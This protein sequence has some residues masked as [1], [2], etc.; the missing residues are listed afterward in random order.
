MAKVYKYKRGD[1]VKVVKKAYEQG[2]WTEEMNE[3]VGDGN[4]YPVTSVWDSN[5][6]VVDDG[7]GF[8]PSALELVESAPRPFIPGLSIPSIGTSVR[9][10]GGPRVVWTGTQWETAV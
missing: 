8:H 7:F 6:I 2:N 1:K 3:Y 9:L 5:T 10:S 4:I